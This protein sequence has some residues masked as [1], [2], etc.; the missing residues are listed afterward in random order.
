[1]WAR[2]SQRRAHLGFRVA[3]FTLLGAEQKDNE[4]DD[5]GRCDRP[6]KKRCTTCC[7]RKIA[8]NNGQNTE[9]DE[10]EEAHADA[11]DQRHAPSGRALPMDGH[12]GAWRQSQSVPRWRPL[13]AK[14]QAAPCGGGEE[15]RRRAGIWAALRRD[16]GGAAAPGGGRGCRGEEAKETTAALDFAVST[17]PPYQATTSDTTAIS[18][19][20]FQSV[21]RRV[22]G[23]GPE[24]NARSKTAVTFN[25]YIK[26]QDTIIV[27][28][29]LRFLTGWRL[30]A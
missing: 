18:T 4:H 12:T 9:K 14:P 5:I 28:F 3:H 8:T 29:L 26:V 13:R 19:L 15:R 27:D 16:W 2:A 23:R 30:R 6:N 1:V 25:I 17:S 10:D 7:R 20:R 11:G 22:G 24:R 21:H